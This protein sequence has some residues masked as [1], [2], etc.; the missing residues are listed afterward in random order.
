MKKYVAY[1][2]VSTEEQGKSGLGLEAQKSSVLQFITTNGELVGEYQDIESGASENR[3]GLDKAI[4]DCQLYGA[5]LVVKELSRITRGGFKYR[6]LLAKSNT[7]FIECS[8][9]YDPEIVKDIKFS[10]AKEERVKIRQ[11]TSDSLAE[12]KRKIE[13]GEEHISKSGNVVTS[14]GNPANLTEKARQKSIETR[15]RLARLNPNNKRASAFIAAL[16]DTHNFKQ[17]TQKLN[18]AGFKTSRGN[19]FSEV[20]TKRLYNRHEE[21]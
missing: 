6:E 18:E 2:R 17:I 1:Y 14:L 5:T 11:R 8:S 9:P 4:L 13:N 21:D 3:V 15:K 19:D 20:Q 7:D 12:I 16:V 10:L